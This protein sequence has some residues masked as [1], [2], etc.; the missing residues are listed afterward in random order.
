MV[1]ARIWGDVDEDQLG[2][3]ITLIEEECR[4]EM[5]N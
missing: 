1:T 3:F 5:S 4:Q 2:D